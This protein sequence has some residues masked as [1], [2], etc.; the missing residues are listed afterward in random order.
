MS[1]SFELLIFSKYKLFFLVHE[2]CILHVIKILGADNKG[3][4][5]SCMYFIKED[6]RMLMLF[7]DAEWRTEF[8]CSDE[9]W[10]AVCASVCHMHYKKTDIWKIWTF[11]LIFKNVSKL[12][13]GSR[14]P[15][16]L[17]LWDKYILLSR[18]LTFSIC[19]RQE[20]IGKPSTD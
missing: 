8:L 4:L 2:E 16:R 18:Q 10:N 9:L 17:V 3:L 20:P 19:S 14:K 7:F 5:I 12:M 6:S 11:E 1:E 15:R 13:Q